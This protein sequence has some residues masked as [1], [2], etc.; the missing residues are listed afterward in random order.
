[1]LLLIVNLNERFCR[2]AC[3]KRASL[4]DHGLTATVSLNVLSPAAEPR[5]D[6]IGKR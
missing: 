4:D 2:Q 6:P 1:M 5:H 3:Y